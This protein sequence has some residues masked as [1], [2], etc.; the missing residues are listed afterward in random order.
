M[1]SSSDMASHL[2]LIPMT[3]IIPPVLMR[4]PGGWWL[5]VE[6]GERRVLRRGHRHLAIG[7]MDHVGAVRLGSV[8]EKRGRIELRRLRVPLLFTVLSMPIVVGRRDGRDV[9]L[10]V[11]GWGLTRFWG[12][13][14]RELPVESRRVTYWGSHVGGHRRGCRGRGHAWCNRHALWLRRVGSVDVG[15]CATSIKVRMERKGER[16]KTARRLRKRRERRR[17]TFSIALL[18]GTTFHTLFPLLSLRVDT[19][20]SDAVLDAAEAG[21][22]VV[23]FLARFLT[24]C[25]CVLDLPAL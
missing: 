9:E 16:R 17:H 12:R 2:V 6:L 10:G 22:G 15:A 5:A 1:Q 23:A 8:R 11:V 21:T 3:M 7:T 14:G 19:L 20:F 13:W 18:V 4:T 25:A 24:I